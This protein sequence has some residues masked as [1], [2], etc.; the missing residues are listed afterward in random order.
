[1]SKV[2]KN[3][4]M[5]E[6]IGMHDMT[7]ICLWSIPGAGKTSAVMALKDK[8][9]RETKEDYQ[10]VHFIASRYTAE[11][12]SGPMI[13]SKCGKYAERL[14]PDIWRTVHEKPTIFFADDFTTAGYVVRGGLLT[15]FSERDVNGLKAHPLSVFILGCNE[16]H[17]TTNGNPM[18]AAE[19][20]RFRHIKVGTDLAYKHM[21]GETSKHL[22]LP[23]KQPDPANQA[24]VRLYITRNP[25]SME[26]SDEVIAKAIDDQVPY[27]TYRSVFNAVAQ[28]GDRSAWPQY[29]GTGWCIGFEAFVANQSLPDGVEILSGRCKDVPERGDEVMAVSQGLLHLLGDKPTDDAIK[30]S[31]EWARLASDKGHTEN[32]YTFVKLL[33]R[34]VGAEKSMVHNKVISSFFDV[35]QH[36]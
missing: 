10:L 20:T 6:L 35:S 24:L 7:P 3:E 18:A 2:K 22:S 27:A 12:V 8:L 29:V 4:M 5:S 15:L 17:H 1:M 11:M 30:F 23:Y 16:A 31:F 34:K 13:P 9:S 21:I 25:A 36:L 26:P 14:T 28:E 19:L 32:V 33:I